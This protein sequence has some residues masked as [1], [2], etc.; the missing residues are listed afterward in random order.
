MAKQDSEDDLVVNVDDLDTVVVETDATTPQEVVKEAKAPKEPKTKRV[1][2]D[3][4]QTVATTPT[5]HEQALAE[6]KAFAKQ[7]EEARRAAEA[8]AA[9]ERAMREQ[10]ERQA[11]QAQQAYNEAQE[12]AAN[13]ELAVIDNGIAAAQAQVE[14]LQEEFTRAAEAGEFAKMGVIQT[15][16]SKAAA[17]LDRLENTK[18]TF[19]IASKTAEGRVEAPVVQQNA[20]EKYVSAFAPQA[21]NWIR[22]HPDCV[23]PAVGGNATRHNLMMAGHYAAI[24]KGILEGT[25]EYFRTIEEH[26]SPPAAQEVTPTPTSKASEVV[27]AVVERPAPRAQ[28]SAPVTRDAPAGNAPR[29]VREVRLTK[30]QQEMAKVSFPHLPEAQAYGQYAR[31]LIE[32]ESE[33]KIGRS[34]H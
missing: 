27:T 4:Q 16:I 8:T 20:F 30:D 28:P 17:A 9:S 33:G 18:A 32:L 29:N 21:Q 10:A 15:K 14:S 11:Q 23:P 26:L 12:R 22:Q 31:N 19:D 3:D 5:D 34:T 13:S 2:L 7:Q 6:A 25:S 24:G 1:L